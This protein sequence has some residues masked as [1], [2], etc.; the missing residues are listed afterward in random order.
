M[1]SGFGFLPIL[2]VVEEKHA[3]FTASMSL[4]SEEQLW[5][6]MSKGLS[7]SK[8]RLAV[9]EKGWCGVAS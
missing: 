1:D 8:R 9:N 3:T 7:I 4:N 5:H 6:L 2:E